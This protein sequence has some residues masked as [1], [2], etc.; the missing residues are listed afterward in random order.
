M[1]DLCEFLVKCSHK[2]L[3]VEWIVKLKAF[4]SA[5]FYE[6]KTIKAFHFLK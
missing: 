4:L 3:E 2:L 1:D 5:I 6:S